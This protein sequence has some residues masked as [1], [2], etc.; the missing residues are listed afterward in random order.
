MAVGEDLF[1]QVRAA[2]IDGPR[3]LVASG[4]SCHEQLQA[5]LNRE[6]FHPMELLATICRSITQHSRVK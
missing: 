6:V 3:I 5:G 4:T 1:A 2:E